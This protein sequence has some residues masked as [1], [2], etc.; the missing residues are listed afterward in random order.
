MNIISKLTIGA[1]EGRGQ[2]RIRLNQQHTGSLLFFSGKIREILKDR[3]GC[4]AHGTSRNMRTRDILVGRGGEHFQLPFLLT[5]YVETRIMSL[6]HSG[7]SR[8]VALGNFRAA[9][10]TLLPRQRHCDLFPAR[11]SGKTTHLLELHTVTE[12]MFLPFII[13]WL[14]QIGNLNIN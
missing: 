11:H 8:I 3:A 7:C 2:L 1:L 5:I 10:M 12:G 14:G 6:K 9:V 4:Q 13:H